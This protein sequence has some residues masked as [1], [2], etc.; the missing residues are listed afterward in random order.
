MSIRKNQPWKECLDE[1]GSSLHIVT[2]RVETQDGI[3][4]HTVCGQT[5]ERNN[6]PDTGSCIRTSRC[7]L[8]SIG[9]DAG[10]V[11]E[12]VTAVLGI[13]GYHVSGISYDALAA[14]RERYGE[15]SRTLRAMVEKELASRREEHNAAK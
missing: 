1:R 12:M 7:R 11:D 2:G 5:L 6:I 10:V 15:K 14:I 8:C 13:D 4:Y 9:V 3:F